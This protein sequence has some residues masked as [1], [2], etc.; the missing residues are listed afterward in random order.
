[1][2]VVGLGAERG[3]ACHQHRG[4][5]LVEAVRYLV[6]VHSGVNP[7]LNEIKKMFYIDLQLKAKKDKTMHVS[8]LSGHGGDSDALGAVRVL[9]GADKLYVATLAL[10]HRRSMLNEQTKQNIEYR[11]LTFFLRKSPDSILEKRF[12]NCLEKRVLS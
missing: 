9:V 10:W 11:L 6:G 4:A 5:L 7:T 3:Y 12:S 8:L 1:M 2:A